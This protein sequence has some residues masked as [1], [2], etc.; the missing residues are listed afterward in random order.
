MNFMPGNSLQSWDMSI[1]KTT[2]FRERYRT[3]LR[4]EFFNAFN[5]TS[6]A[7]PTNGLENPN[8]GRTFSTSISPRTIQLGL[9][10]YW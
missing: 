10:F 5:H 3:E 4:G 7:N 2:A 8:F 6:F 1:A 9:K